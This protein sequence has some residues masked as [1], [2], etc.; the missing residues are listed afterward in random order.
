MLSLLSLPP[1]LLGS[2]LFLA[3]P[4]ATWANRRVTFSFPTQGCSSSRDYL[5]VHGPDKPTMEDFWSL[6]W[7]QDVHTILTLLPWQEKGEVRHCAHLCHGRVGICSV[8]LEL[9]EFKILLKTLKTLH[10]FLSPGCRSSLAKAGPFLCPGAPTALSWETGSVCPPCLDS[11]RALQAASAWTKGSS[12]CSAQPGCRHWL[13]RVQPG[14]SGLP[15]ELA[16]PA[17][18]PRTPSGFRWGDELTWR[19]AGSAL[20]AAPPQTLKMVTDMTMTT[21]RKPNFLLHTGPR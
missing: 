1:D 20:G 5:A 12:S 2:L 18:V 7:E 11:A 13:S 21:C 3:I 17:G 15:D 19:D 8:E 4:A 9:A 14:S 6:V 16:E 10:H